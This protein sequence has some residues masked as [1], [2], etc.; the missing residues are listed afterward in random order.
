MRCQRIAV[1]NME[2]GKCFNW[3]LCS[4][5]DFLII[6]FV[7]VWSIVGIGSNIMIGVIQ[8]RIPICLTLIIII[9]SKMLVN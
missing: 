7:L 2:G 6:A 8:R 3:V 5:R 4:C 9:H 1:S